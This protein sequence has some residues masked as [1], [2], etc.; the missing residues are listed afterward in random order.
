MQAHRRGSSWQARGIDRRQMVATLGAWPAIVRAQV[1]VRVYRVGMVSLAGGEATWRPLAEGLSALG[2][3]NGHNLELRSTFANG[4]PGRLSAM[5][6]QMVRDGVD[7][8]VTSGNRETRAALAATSTIPV[9]MLFVPDPVSQGFV[10]SL[11]RPGGNA[12]GLTNMVPGL[13]QKYVELMRELL[14]DAQQL[15]VVTSPSNPVREHRQE[16]DSAA[17]RARL[18]LRYVSIATEAEVEPAISLARRNGASGIVVTQD[19]LTFQHRRI[20]VQAA[21]K[22]RLPGIY[23]A[24]EYVDAG[25]FMTYS[26]RIADLVRRGATFVDKL[27][28]GAQVAELPVEQP[29]T[30]ELVVNLKAAEAAG[31]KVPSSFLLR[32][33]ELLR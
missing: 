2:Y 13:S 4:D 12:T 25:G 17:S 32:A 24:R 27:L 22:Q 23:W 18:S 31:I 1:A 6:E 33:D 9:V 29:T 26:A 5:V 3:V 28:R 16:L 15:A 11:A 7:V 10:K 21:E 20:L 19:P 14:P 30:F 8:I